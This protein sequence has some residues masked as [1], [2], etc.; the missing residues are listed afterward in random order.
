MKP[1]PVIAQQLGPMGINMGKV[2]ADIN[3]ATKDFSGMQVPVKLDID[4]KTKEYSIKVLSPPVSALIKKEAG[5]E[6]ASGS[7]KK[8]QCGNLSIEQLIS[9]TKQKFT[10]MLAKDFK[11]A[12][13]SVLGSAMTLGI[14]IESRDPKEIIQEVKEGKFDKLINSQ[15]TESSPEKLAELKSYFSQIKSKQEAVK[16]SEDEAKAAE[17]A[18]KAQAAVAKPGAAVA[19]KPGA[20]AAKPAAKPAAKK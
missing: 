8:L 15:V 20:A 9:V 19:A 14:L 17:E 7:R 18:K 4:P 1:S 13:L 6:T 3:I 2:I 12:F 11:S 5:I 16:K 10:N